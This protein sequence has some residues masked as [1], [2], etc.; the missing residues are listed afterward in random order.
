M[1]QKKKRYP[2]KPKSTSSLDVWKNWEKKAAEIKKHN[3]AI[4]RERAAKQK[5]AKRFS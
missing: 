3:D 1:A 2:K 4:E 5:I